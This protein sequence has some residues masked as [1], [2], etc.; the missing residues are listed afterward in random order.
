MADKVERLLRP[1]EGFEPV[2]PHQEVVD[3]LRHADKPL[4]AVFRDQDILVAELQHLVGLD[5]FPAVDVVG[6]AEF[7]EP[8]D[9]DTD[10][11]RPE[12][13]QGEI[14]HIVADGPV[15][16]DIKVLQRPE[17]PLL[18]RLHRPLAGDQ[19]FDTLQERDRRLAHAEVRERRRILDPDVD[20]NLLE[21]DR[22]NA[23]P[24]AHI[25]PDLLAALRAPEDRPRVRPAVA[26]V[27]V[28][29]RAAGGAAPLAHIHLDHAAVRVRPGP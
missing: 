2:N 3:E 13:G 14:D 7:A 5:E 20:R 15:L 27:L 18:D 11:V 17:D 24:G 16:E 1:V 9:R 26:E 29:E 28:S 4:A 25:L 19:A 10:L 8:L 22:R 12:M 21:A 6:V 23:A